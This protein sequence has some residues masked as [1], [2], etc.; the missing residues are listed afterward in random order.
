M[1]IFKEI[2]RLT[3]APA[4]NKQSFSLYVKE[5]NIGGEERNTFY[6]ETRNLY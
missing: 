1:K 6:I 5:Y 4:R 3:L 2:T